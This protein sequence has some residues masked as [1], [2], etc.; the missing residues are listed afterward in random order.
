[1][2]QVLNPIWLFAIG[3]IIIP[4]I[5]HLWNVKK[6]K[7]LKVGSISLL[8][9]SSRQ[10]AKSLK[11]IDLLLLLLRCLLLIILAII[12]AKPIWNS[13]NTE[14]TKS[15]W[16]LIEEENS[17]A[18]YSNFKSEIDSL[19]RLGYDLRY[20]EPNF[21]KIK[22]EDIQKGITSTKDKNEAFSYWPLLDLLNVKIPANTK[23]FLFTGNRLTKL[24]NKRA[25]ISFPLTWKTITPT[26]STN[27]WLEN[28]WFQESGSIMATIAT[29]S[30]AAT[31]YST[32]AFD[33]TIKNSRLTLNFEQGLANLHYKDTKNKNSH[34]LIIDTTGIKIAIY[35]DKFKSDAN[36][37]KAAIRA[38]KTY[39]SL[40]IELQ[41]Y[42]TKDIPSGQNIIFWL[43]ESAIPKQISPKTKILTYENG[44]VKNVSTTLK[45]DQNTSDS[46]IGLYKRINIPENKPDAFI[47]WEDGFGNPILSQRQEKNYTKIEFYSRFNPDWNELVWGEDLPKALINIILSKNNESKIHE[48]DNRKVSETQMLPIFTNQKKALLDKKPSNTTDLANHFWLALILIFMLERYLSFKNNL[49]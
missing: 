5:I 17:K 3:G 8:G 22:I 32:E 19:D 37:I 1:M 2:L 40:K 38:I 33:P 4:L 14:E 25:E 18:I 11:L 39:T 26:D 7:T 28:A 36:Y 27:S 15:A 9:E 29:S 35:T 23:A 47:I 6:G 42:S 43:S 34:S 41:E 12:L 49:R 24:G 46:E 45:L 30:P 48:L 44:E 16:I 13:I 20:F 21:R 10:S 31:T